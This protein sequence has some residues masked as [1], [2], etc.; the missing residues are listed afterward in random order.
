MSSV[1]LNHKNSQKWFFWHKFGFR[2]DN[3]VSDVPNRNIDTV[4]S[5]DIHDE[6]SDTDTRLVNPD[7]NKALN[8]CDFDEID[9][10]LETGFETKKPGPKSE[11][12]LELINSKHRDSGP[13]ENVINDNNEVGIDTGKENK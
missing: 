12:K 10:E 7:E 13:Y 4:D 6:F 8:T 11:R 2:Y 1:R 5:S 9:C 3:V